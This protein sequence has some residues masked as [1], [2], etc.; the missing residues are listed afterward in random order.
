[1]L[2]MPAIVS[3]QNL[4]TFTSLT[5]ALTNPEVGLFHVQAITWCSIQFR[6][7]WSKTWIHNSLH[8]YDVNVPDPRITVGLSI[9]YIT[10]GI[11]RNRVH[12][13]IVVFDPLVKEYFLWSHIWMRN[14]LQTRLSC[15][16]SAK[17]NIILNPDRNININ[18]FYN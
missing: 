2:K 9:Y 5:P 17:E 1:M 8:N 13:G 4:D 18:C 11:L 3:K 6:E 15:T 16:E 12:S 14:I 7:N 10:R